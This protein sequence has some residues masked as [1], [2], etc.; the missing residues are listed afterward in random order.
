MQSN[1][2]DNCKELQ[3]H[4]LLICHITATHFHLPQ[5]KDKSWDFTLIDKWVGYVKMMEHLFSNVFTLTD[6]SA[7]CTSVSNASE[8]TSLCT[9]ALTPNV[10][11]MQT[12][13]LTNR[14][15]FSIFLLQFY[16]WLTILMDSTSIVA[17]EMP[18]EKNKIH[19]CPSNHKMTTW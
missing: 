7:N 16:N 3:T 13:L 17:T 10:A 4:D 18:V 15:M 14:F 6:I 8:M 5:T 1:F 2:K 12:T 9:I 11:N 19:V